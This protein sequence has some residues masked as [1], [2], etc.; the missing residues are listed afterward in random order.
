V[1][2]AGQRRQGEGL[3]PLAPIAEATDW[4]TALPPCADV[5]RLPVRRP[6]DADGQGAVWQQ[7]AAL[8]GDLWFSAVH[9]G[10]QLPQR[11][12][13]RQS[14]SESILPAQQAFVPL[15]E[16]MTPTAFLVRPQP[17]RWAVPLAVDA[18]ADAVWVEYTLV[19]LAGQYYVVAQ[20]AYFAGGV[21]GDS[22]E[23]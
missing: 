12:A 20:D 8:A 13:R 23:D 16:S 18:Q 3:I 11:G 17:G 6:G 2:P 9:A 14:Q 15:P 1:R 19:V 21:A 10:L 5:V 22:V 4:L 7:A